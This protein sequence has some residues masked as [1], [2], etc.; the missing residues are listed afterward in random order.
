[1]SVILNSSRGLITSFINLLNF[2]DNKNN[3]SNDSLLE[4][5]FPEHLVDIVE[6]RGSIAKFVQPLIV[7]FPLIISD[8]LRSNDYTKY[9]NRFNIELFSLFYRQVFTMLATLNGLSPRATI[10]I[11]STSKLTR[12]MYD[13]DNRGN[14]SV[15]KS[16]NLLGKDI[17]NLNDEP[18]LLKDD[19]DGGFT[20]GKEIFNEIKIT[21]HIQHVPG[22]VSEITIPIGIRAIPRYVDFEQIKNAVIVRGDKF[23]I[24]TRAQ[25]LWYG[26]ISV[27][28]FFLPLKLL[29]EYRQGLLKD[30]SDVLKSM[31]AQENYSRKTLRNIDPT[32]GR[33]GIGNISAIGFERFYGALAI[34]EMEAG[35][36]AK[37]MMTNREH[38]S[39][40][41]RLLNAANKMILNI[42]DDGFGNM[43][44]SVLDMPHTSSIALKDLKHKKPGEDLTNILSQLV[45]SQNSNKSIF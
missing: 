41:D 20:A 3:S 28:E 40:P 44:Y 14:W 5:E 35:I 25:E 11:L 15:T 7:S 36:L 31:E 45:G 17:L 1:M 42:V 10:D 33:S 2:M 30:S 4:Y 22:K 21:L 18:V 24:V 34:S 19:G 39:F 38:K 29:R 8:S 13:A 37:S 23:S 26:E 16:F 6:A 27:A 43:D 9:I 32:T 12:A